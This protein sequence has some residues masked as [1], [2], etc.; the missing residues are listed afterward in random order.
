MPQ[1]KYLV[2]LCF[3]LGFFGKWAAAQ[4]TLPDITLATENG[5]NIVSWINP[6]KSGVRAFVI[7]R[8]TDSNVNFSAIGILKKFENNIQSFVDVAPLAG[9]NWYRVKVIFDSEIE[10]VSNHAKITLDSMAIV[11]RK[12]IKSVDTLQV[13]V[14]EALNKEGSKERIIDTKIK[15]V[16][17]PKSKYIYS[18]PFSGN[19]VIELPETRDYNY[20][21]TFYTEGDKQL[22]D[23]PRI[24]EDEIILD[25]R[26]FQNNGN[27][28]FTIWRDDKIFEKGMI[29][30]Y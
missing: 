27:Y 12:L 23:I 14:N 3:A 11:N 28:K 19:I 2:I 15:Q 10:W 6:Y 17:I 29:T 25:K 5:I 26:N 13:A 21:I 16:E 4:S 8:S 24:H 20:K 9:S 1:I 18:N 7:E 22:F 30:I